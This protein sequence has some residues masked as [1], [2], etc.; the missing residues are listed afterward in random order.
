M[1]PAPRSTE[2]MIEVRMVL[3]SVTAFVVICLM[4]GCRGGRRR[5]RKKLICCQVVEA[6]CLTIYE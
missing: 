6:C 1:T 2:R 5:R 3:R 4:F